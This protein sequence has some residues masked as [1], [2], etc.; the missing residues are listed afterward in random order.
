MGS[1][2]THPH[3][4]YIQVL[5]ELGL[6]GFT[7]LIS[8]FLYLLFISLRQFVLLMRSRVDKLIPFEIFLYPMILFIF[9]WPIIPHMSF[10]NNWNNVLLMLPLGFLMRY[11]YSNSENGNFN[12]I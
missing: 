5:A 4:F 10:Y 6:V 11:L 7:F 12:K 9:W 1:C 3:N 8:F 2:S